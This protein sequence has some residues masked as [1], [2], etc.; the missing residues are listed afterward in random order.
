MWHSPWESWCHCALHCS[1]LLNTPTYDTGLSL[2]HSQTS[3]YPQILTRSTTIIKNSRS[4]NYS[5]YVCMYVC[6]Y[7]G[8]IRFLEADLECNTWYPRR[9]VLIVTY[10]MVTY[11]QSQMWR[12]FEIENKPRE[13]K[14]RSQQQ[15]GLLSE[16]L[17]LGLWTTGLAWLF[18]TGAHKCIERAYP[19]NQSWRP[20]YPALSS[21][22]FRQNFC[23]VVQFFRIELGS[24]PENVSAGCSWKSERVCVCVRE[25]ERARERRPRQPIKRCHHSS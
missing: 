10:W 23:F 6:M 11:V 25:R 13:S 9:Y 16:S 19:L 14:N 21:V 12:P 7:I 2:N 24:C 17:L 8:S 15:D 4:S 18:G 1:R 22:W 3:L 20:D 5:M